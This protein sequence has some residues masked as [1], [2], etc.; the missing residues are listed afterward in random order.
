[1]TTYGDNELWASLLGS[2][3]L[4]EC[5]DSFVVAPYKGKSARAP[6]K[7]IASPYGAWTAD[8]KSCLT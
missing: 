6:M 7:M 8:E 3:T 1:M 2:A 5:G 4:Q